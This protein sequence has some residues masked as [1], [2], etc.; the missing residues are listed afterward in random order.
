MA[1]VAAAL[2]ALAAWWWLP[3]RDASL[4]RLG[5]VEERARGRAGPWFRSVVVA[6]ACLVGAALIAG[7]RGAALGLCLLILGGTVLGLWARRRRRA[8]EASRRAEVV[9]AGEL[10]AGLL[11]VGRVPTTALIEAAQDA[12]VL[13]AA[14]AEHAAGGDAAPAFRRESGRPG[15]A[16][17]AELADA[18]EVAVRTGA[19]LVE[20]V[21]AA[22]Q[23]LADEGDVA[24]VVATEL[25]SARLAGRMMAALPFAGLLIGYALGA[26]P[27]GF[28][29]GSP[30]GWV[31]LNVG[32]A[33][34]CAGVW[35]IDTV[36]ARAG[37]R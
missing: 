9:H 34:A 6:A 5:A 16:G 37:G 21:D 20:S 18:W 24:R 29:L 12:P 23:R 25:A 1:L 14:A 28:L 13:A 35:W 33:L 2:A 17:M 3:A 11:R 4:R 27:L 36:A 10:I 22:A 32:V 8:L 15:C 30:A 26:D 19:S 7:P 31:C